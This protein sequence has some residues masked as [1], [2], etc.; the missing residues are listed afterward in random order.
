[1]VRAP[2]CCYD[3][4]REMPTV[5]ADIGFAR[6]NHSLT[7]PYMINGFIMSVGYLL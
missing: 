4:E 3:L 5:L 2:A 1:M 7:I 6:K